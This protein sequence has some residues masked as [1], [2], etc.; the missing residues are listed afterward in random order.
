M[1][2]N[3]RSLLTFRIPSGAAVRAAG[4]AALRAARSR[5]TLRDVLAIVGL[6]LLTRV[7]FW[8]LVFRGEIFPYGTTDTHNWIATAQAFRSLFRDYSPFAERRPL[9]PMFNALVDL[10]VDDIVLSGQITSMSASV[11]T[12]VGVYFLGR[13]LFGRRFALWCALALL[14]HYSVLVFAIFNESYTTHACLTVFLAHV[15]LLAVREG[16]IV[17][18]ALAGLLAAASLLTVF[19]GIALPAVVVPLLMIVSLARWRSTGWRVA[20]QLAA[21]FGTFA[22][23]M[24]LDGML[25]LERT[26]GTGEINYRISAYLDIQFDLNQFLVGVLRL[27]SGAWDLVGQFVRQFTGNLFG[28]YLY[29]FYWPGAAFLLFS[30]VALVS[31]R[32]VRENDP[33]TMRLGISRGA[34]YLLLLHVVPLAALAMPYHQ[35]YT[36]HAEPLSFVLVTAGIWNLWGLV[37]RPALWT[38][39]NADPRRAK[40]WAHVACC[41]F[42]VLL[43]LCPLAVRG[44][45]LHGESHVVKLEMERESNQLVHWVSRR[46]DRD[47]LICSVNSPLPAHTLQDRETCVLHATENSGEELPDRGSPAADFARQACGYL[48]SRPMYLFWDTNIVSAGSVLPTQDVIGALELSPCFLLLK[49]HEAV[50]LDGGVL[51]PRLLWERV[52]GVD[53]E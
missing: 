19:W 33:A 51:G 34:L 24:F 9:Y 30:C 10:G 6:G 20:L 25:P 48:P 12:A 1:G 2:Q 11:L 42:F 43:V 28:H 37:N 52:P 46:S 31:I 50:A 53:A 40:L 8:I 14:L 4:R 3:S 32:R 38:R 47:A 39:G 22:V 5:P 18:F 16:R 49:R 45:K 35:R 29:G 17:H 36:L 21:L 41:G 13:K 23:V 26:A 44:Y 27:D 15:T 7:T